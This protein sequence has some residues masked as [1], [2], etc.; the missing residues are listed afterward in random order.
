MRKRGALW[1]VDTALIDACY[2]H[3][4]K[5]RLKFTLITR[6]KREFKF[7]RHSVLLPAREKP[8]Q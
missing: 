8:F 1:L 6:M 3:E 7:L 5:S 2:W 4:Q